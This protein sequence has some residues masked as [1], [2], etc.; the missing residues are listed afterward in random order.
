MHYDNNLSYPGVIDYNGYT[1][2]V[3]GEAKEERKAKIKVERWY[4]KESAKNK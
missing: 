4:N 3:N 1:V 2:L